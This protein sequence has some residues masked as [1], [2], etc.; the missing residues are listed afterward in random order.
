MLVLDPALESSASVSATDGQILFAGSFAVP[1]VTAG[2]QSTNQTNKQTAKL[3]ASCQ[4][5]QI[6]YSNDEITAYYFF[7]QFQITSMTTHNGEK[8]QKQV[9]DEE[10]HLQ[11][12][13][14]Q[15]G[16]D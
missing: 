15:V 13:D 8:V 14:L 12:Q 7:L 5:S 6:E 4:L 11:G 1:A 3:P 2:Y 9:Q 16:N 10:D